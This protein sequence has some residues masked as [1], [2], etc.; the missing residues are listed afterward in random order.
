M[1]RKDVDVSKRRGSRIRKKIQQHKKVRDLPPEILEAWTDEL[2]REP[3]MAD[4][5][6]VQLKMVQVVLRR[7]VELKLAQWMETNL[8]I[9]KDEFG[10]DEERLA[11]FI[12]EF[13]R[14]SCEQ[15]TE[16]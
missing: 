6:D 15:A 10:F 8:L 14:R 12:S 13:M 4:A 16:T 7:M 11:K 2:G 9:L 5:T 1:D 3:R